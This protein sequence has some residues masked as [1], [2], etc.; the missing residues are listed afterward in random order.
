M[1]KIVLIFAMVLFSLT[2]WAQLN[3]SQDFPYRDL[4]RRFLINHQNRNASL[5]V[6]KAAE[7]QKLD[8]AV[9]PEVSKDYYIYNNERKNTQHISYVWENLHWVN[10]EKE[11]FTFGPNGLLLSGLGYTWN[12]T[13]GQWILASKYEVTYAN[14][15]VSVI[16]AS[17]W[18]DNQW[19]NLVKFESAYDANNNFTSQFVYTW[20][21]VTLQWDNT[22][23]FTYEYDQLNRRN[24][25]HEW[26]WTNNTWTDSK[27]T[28]YAYDANGNMNLSYDYM[29]DDSSG[30]WFLSERGLFTY[31]VNKRLLTTIHALPLG[32]DIWMNTRKIEYTYDYTVDPGKLILPAFQED[33]FAEYIDIN[34]A[35]YTYYQWNMMTM[36]WSLTSVN[37]KYFSDFDLSVPSLSVSTNALTIGSA[38]NSTS[39]F[40]ITSTVN[41]TVSSSE[42]WLTPGDLSG[43]GNKTI[44]LTATANPNTTPRTAT[45]TVSATGLPSQNITV[46]QTGLSIQVTLLLEGAYAAQ[47]LMNTALKAG[48][49]LPLAQPYNVAPWN[50]EGTENVA[51]IP[52]DV[53]DWVLVELR[54]AATPEAALPAT[55]LSGWPRACLLK[56]NGTIVGTDGV[57]PPSLG[58]PTITGNL[59]VIIRHR[60]H[61]AIMS[62]TG[63][64]LTG[65]NYV[66]NFTDAITKAHGGA[67][68]YKEIAAGFFGM[69]S[70]DP[71]GDGDISVLDFSEW[72]TDFGKTASYLPADMDA[73]GEVSV[74]DFSKWA[75]NFGVGNIPPLKKLRLDGPVRKYS[76][77]VPGSR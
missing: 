61:I 25:S 52:A 37:D 38:A 57:T 10:S 16:I 43:T 15:L 54:Q 55:T 45:V 7:Y 4:I 76:S 1:K 69:V 46:T 40:D 17:E 47:G 72:A 29:W 23:K 39:T 58:N 2:T 56:S 73:D 36:D 8:S 6:L 41:W 51:A 9:T 22:W 5:P 71:D 53:V 30:D 18:T 32:N 64:A 74:L 65:G 31:D 59:Y 27:K 75:T 24:L 13:S 50:Y 48:A 26:L 60:N 44:T 42:S 66:Y 49:L 21:K 63:M 12:A 67:A 70:G 35:S 11:E 68:G 34:A 3:K 20:N 14:N 77:Q 28:T 62:A 33:Y 19:I